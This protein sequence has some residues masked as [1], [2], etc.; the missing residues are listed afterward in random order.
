MY[1]LEL[2]CRKLIGELSHMRS[3]E[4]LFR[5]ID[6]GPSATNQILEIISSYSSDELEQMSRNYSPFLGDRLMHA[7]IRA[8]NVVL[9]TKLIELKL[10]VNASKAPGHQS[11]DMSPLSLAAQENSVECLAALLAVMSEEDLQLPI[12]QDAL[13][14]SFTVGAIALNPN[15]DTLTCISLLLKS[16]INPNYAVNLSSPMNNRSL[17]GS[18][19]LLSGQHKNFGIVK[20]LLA[21]GANPNNG[22]EDQDGQPVTPLLECLRL[23][24]T[25]GDY[26]PFELILDAKPTIDTLIQRPSLRGDKCFIPLIFLVAMEDEKAFKELVARGADV[27]LLALLPNG[28]QVS[29][30]YLVDLFFKNGSEVLV[31]F[32]EGVKERFVNSLC[33]AKQL[34]LDAGCQTFVGA[35]PGKNTIFVQDIRTVTPELENLAAG[36]AEALFP[37]EKEDGN[38]ISNKDDSR[39]CVIC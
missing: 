10:N 9:L 1:R 32:N 30:D 34:M 13:W 24:K 15:E 3:T 8:K 12:N 4:N 18:A 11:R 39:D 6:Q 35:I 25:T 7:A 2:K 14:A 29:C 23:A 31:Q 28:R 19:L 36:F 21:H 17:L 38:D 33:G 22:G 27:N 26:A 16:G 37:A 5:L 20:I